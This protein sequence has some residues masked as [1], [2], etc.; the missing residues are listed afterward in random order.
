MHVS[1]RHVIGQS[2]AAAVLSTSPAEHEDTSFN[3]LEPNDFF[4]M[5]AM[6]GVVTNDMDYGVITNDMDLLQTRKQTAG[7]ES[8]LAEMIRLDG[9]GDAGNMCAGCAVMIHKCTVTGCTVTN[10]LCLPTHRIDEWTGVCFQRTSLKKLGLRIQLGHPIGQRCILPHKAFNDDFV[11]MDTDGI[12]QVGLDFCGC[13]TAQTHT[14]QLLRNRWFPSTSTDPRTAATFRVLRQYHILS[15]ESKASA[16]EFYHTLVRLTDNTGLSNRKADRYEAFM[17][18]VREW[19]HLKMVKRFGRGH[20]PAGVK[21]TSPGECAI[22]CPACP[23]PGKNLP[24]GW[25]D[26]G[27]AKRWLYAIFVAIDANFRLKRRDV[28]NEDVDPSLSKG[29]AYFM[30]EKG[31]K[32]FLAQHLGDEQEPM[33]IHTTL[34]KS[35]CSNHNAVNM[36]DT[37]LSQGLAA[38]GVGTIDCARH[39]MKRPNG[40]G[41]LQKGEKYLN[42]DY[43]T[44]LQMLNVS[45]DIACQWHKNLWAR[46]KSFPQSHSLDYLTKVIRFFV[47]KFHL[48][49]H[50]AKCQTLFSF[51]FTRFVGHTDGEAPERGWSNINPVA[52]S[53][54]AMGPGCRR[55]TLDDHFGDWNWKKTVGL[56]ASLLLKIKDALAERAEHKMAFEEFDTAI[57]PDHR[58]AWL[59]EMEVWEV[60]PNDT[61]PRTNNHLAITQASARLKLAELEAEELRRGIDTSLHPEI[62]RSIHATDTQKSSIVRMRNLLRRKIDMWRRAH[63]L[64]LP[65]VQSIIN[66]AVREVQE[67][68]ECM[69]LWLPSQLRDKPCDPRLQNDEWEL[70]YAQAHDTLEEIRQCLRI[71]CSLLS[72]KREWIRGQGANTRAQNALA[73]VHGRRTACV[74]RY[75]S[76][77]VA[78]KALA[79]AMGKKDWQGRLQELADNDIKPLVDPFATGEGRRQVSWIWMM[80][81]VDCSDEGD[82]DGVR[83]EWCKSRARA[84]R[85]SEEVELLRE[86]MRRVL[87]FFAWQAAWWEDQGKRRVGECA[88]H[89]EG[90]YAY[91]VR[92]ANLRRRM[93]DDFRILWS[94]Y[95]SPHALP[96]ALPIN[97]PSQLSE[98][99]LPDLTIPDIP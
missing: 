41:D 71:H 36:A 23:Q 74:K 72:F 26:V 12:H 8:Y 18:M 62:S 54:K 46:M 48:P 89:A 55:D 6:D 30:E 53:T 10:H 28:S 61:T 96:Q 14:K 65:A 93:A 67:N 17:R 78:L 66:H 68:A 31:Y 42:M 25:Q 13:E 3:V 4:T 83:I 15:F 5:D 84:L 27:K 21:A 29:W 59:A 56:G 97:P 43:L 2:S 49:A 91:A 69:K 24:D 50:I 35:S 40:V 77:W 64:Y 33:L 38:T 75:R 19:R 88:A 7:R 52:S 9:R 70:R 57:T 80:D 90:L 16:Y 79:T 76:T 51:N 1:G 45:Y 47:P 87:Q 37:K 94:P 11:I 98:L 32:T 99:S 39:N 82:N 60:N 95:L 63:V 34:Q 92:Q 81:G 86:E 85:W 20:D 44:Q 22:L 73:R 58:S